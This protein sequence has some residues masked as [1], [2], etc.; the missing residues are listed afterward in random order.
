MDYFEYLNRLKA[1]EMKL[2]S[3]LEK[4]EKYDKSE[5]NNT[6][7]K[8]AKQETKS[9]KRRSLEESPAGK[10]HVA[11]IIKFYCNQPAIK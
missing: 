11:F 3:E 6:K 1:A 9:R 10:L 7:D 8:A 2:K 4:Y 5:D